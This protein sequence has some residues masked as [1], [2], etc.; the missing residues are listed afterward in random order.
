M[1]LFSIKNLLLIA[2]CFAIVAC[3]DDDKYSPGSPT[4]TNGDNIYFSAD[5]SAALA[6]GTSDNEFTV[7][8][9]RAKTTGSQTVPLMVATPHDT[10]FSVPASVEFAEGEGQKAITVTVSNKMVMFK[11]YALSIA[12]PEEYT[13][14]YAEQNVFPRYEAMVIKEDYQPYA[15]GV[16]GAGFFGQSWTTVLEYSEILDLYRFSN[17][18]VEGYDVTFKWDGSSEVGLS[19]KITTGYVHSTYGMVSATPIECSY[20]AGKKMFS[21]LYEWTVS[22]GTFGEDLDTFTMN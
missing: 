2:S 3:S 4:N 15:T 7:V 14:Q 1:K 8:V 22:A 10:I 11:K 20:D 16:Y 12:I 6:L 13:E 21:F 17:C 18:W 9:Q 5:N 19:G